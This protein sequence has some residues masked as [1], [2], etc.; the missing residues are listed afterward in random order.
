MK[1][2]LAFWMG[3]A[4]SPT[5][6][7]AATTVRFMGSA[8]LFLTPGERRFPKFPK[9]NRKFAKWKPQRRER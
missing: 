6:P 3:G 4:A 8:G 5:A 1:S 9:R 2:L 7:A